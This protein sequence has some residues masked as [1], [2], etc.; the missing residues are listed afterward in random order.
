[1]LN[2]N[3][4]LKENELYKTQIETSEIYKKNRRRN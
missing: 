1:M 2:N 4:Y 3:T